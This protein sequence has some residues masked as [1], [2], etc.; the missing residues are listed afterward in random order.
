[1][2][3]KS[4][5][6]GQVAP[7]FDELKEVV[8]SVDLS[9]ANE[10]QT[11]FQVI[12]RMIREVLCWQ[13]Q[14]VKVEERASESK[15][16]WID[17]VLK[18]GDY[19][20]L[21]EAKRFGA[22]FPSPTSRHRLS[23]S[24]SVLGIGE[25]A[26]AISQAE[27]YAAQFD[28]QFIVVT[29]GA[30]WCLFHTHAREKRL[31]AIMLSPFSRRKQ[32]E[33]LFNLLAEVNV[34]EGSLDYIT[35]E[36]PPLENRLIQEISLLDDRID[37]NN[38]ADFIAP[39][40]NKALYSDSLLQ[41]AENLRRCFIPTEARTKFDRTLQMHLSDTKP[42]EILP[43]RRIRTGRDR[44]PLEQ[45][46]QQDQPTHAPP[47]TLI[48]GP[49]GAGKSTYL[50]HFERVAAAQLLTSTKAH[51]VY[52][53]YE[54]MGPSGNP[55]DFLYS[56]LRT[57]LSTENQANST[58]YKNAI[59]PAYEE[60]IAGLAR[61]PLAP[62]LNNEDKFNEKISEYIQKDYDKI[63]PYVDKIFF[64]LSSKYLTVV[65]LDNVDLYE[66]DELESAVFAEGLAFSKRVH[67]NVIVCIR[68]TTFVR[69]RTDSVFDAY[70]LRKL[71]LDPPP[72]N[73]VLS[74]RLEYSQKILEGTR[75]RIPTS[76]GAHIQVP[77]LGIFFEI[78]QKSILSGEPGHFIN[79]VADVNIRKGLDL[80]TNFLTSGHIQADKA[81]G[82]Y[83][84]K[85][86]NRFR[87]PFHEVFK[88]SMLGQWRHFREDRAECINL[89]DARVGVRKMRLLRLQIIKYLMLR[90]RNRDTLEVPIQELVSTLGPLG[91][92]A[93]TIIDI[94]YA[95]QREGLIR[96]VSMITSPSDGSV[97]ITRSGGYYINKLVYRMVYVEECAYDTAIDDED[98]W[99]KL[100]EITY[101]IENEHSVAKRM[102]DRKK[103]LNIFTKYLQNLE[104][105]I[106][107]VVPQL[108]E[109]AICE[110]IKNQAMNEMAEALRRSQQYYS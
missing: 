83:I 79:A 43:A 40:L 23:L 9:Y 21:V 18:S 85:E 76:G 54:K 88:G 91:S 53:D 49:V 90:A 101:T 15:D 67:C 64:Y 42:K 69:H 68:D 57:Y 14:Q 50:A 8:S 96:Q 106:I 32:A 89:F 60:D 31:D 61:G 107:S 97:S 71:W 65:V 51:W 45:I 66:D 72:F 73:R 92:S 82:I 27:G 4:I 59:R 55:R 22:A 94:I 13:Y 77:D 44:G 70:E 34:R 5:D 102:L 1:M 26:E 86:N 41:N 75:A 104:A 2:S 28:V 17:Y 100:S 12:D 33:E 30:V 95:L 24:G 108:Q 3:D 38:I 58:D 19:T 99:N 78:V 36:S 80:V 105:E 16:S 81:L 52:I 39:A 47:V 87:F 37:R 93:E 6:W 10:A 63:E 35:E 109:I 110:E 48:I 56:E 25:I 29:N 98:T 46:I 7:V 103:R 62:I 20:I 11:R 74:T 84:S